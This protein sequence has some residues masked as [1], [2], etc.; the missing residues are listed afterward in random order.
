M[1]AIALGGV[2]Y[3]YNHFLKP[4]SP[5]LVLDQPARVFETPNKMIVHVC[6]AV[7]REGVY[8]M[9]FGDR[10]IDAL[11]EAGGAKERADLSL[12]NLAEELKDG[13]KVLILEK[14]DKGYKRSGSGISNKADPLGNALI[15][16]NTADEKELDDLPGIG[17]ATAKK[18]IEARPFSKIEDL[19]KIP[20]FGKS[21]LEKIKDSICL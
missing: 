6:G 15:N 4:E 10:I 11:K 5:E 2:V 18:I 7:R 19:L 3:F 1:L 20:R 13:Q 16:V 17:P 9:R 21:R 8:K 14:Q 12:I